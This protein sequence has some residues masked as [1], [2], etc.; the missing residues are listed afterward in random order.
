LRPITKSARQ[1]ETMENA[2]RAALE[3]VV[4]A[5]VVLK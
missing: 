3:R 2:W 4:P 1:T 5:V